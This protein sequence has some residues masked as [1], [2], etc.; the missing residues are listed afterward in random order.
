MPRSHLLQFLDP[1]NLLRSWPL[2]VG[3]FYAE[4]VGAMAL[5]I[6]NWH[7]THFEGTHRL[8]FLIHL[9]FTAI[10]SHSRYAVWCPPFVLADISPLLVHY[11]LF[12]F[13]SP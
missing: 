11:V 2:L 6:R 4:H 5:A 9:I 7:P 1:C 10:L 8:L 12:M 3:G 13:L